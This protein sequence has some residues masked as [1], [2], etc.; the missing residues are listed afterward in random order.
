MMFGIVMKNHEEIYW[1]LFDNSE[2][3]AEDNELNINEMLKEAEKAIC[4]KIE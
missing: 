4:I 1:K 3:G 2:L